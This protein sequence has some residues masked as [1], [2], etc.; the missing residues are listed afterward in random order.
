[1]YRRI[2]AVLA[3]ALVA[4]LGVAAPSQAAVSWKS[5]SSYYSITTN[6]SGLGRCIVVKE[7]GN[8]KYQTSVIVGSDR[9]VIRQIRNPRLYSP[10]TTVLFYDKCGSGRKLKPLKSAR[11]QLVTAWSDKKKH[12]GSGY[13]LSASVPWGLS[14]SGTVSSGKIAW[15]KRSYSSNTAT[16]SKFT[17]TSSGTAARW[18]KSAMTQVAAGGK[19][20]YPKIKLTNEL[21]KL[22]I[23]QGANAHAFLGDQMPQKSVTVW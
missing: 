18:T 1:M 13:G 14:V 17:I 10:Q 7:T 5:M 9:S 15:A 8:I 3:A 22:V 12:Y 23:H 6:Y 16:T 2:A 4:V 21:H 19:T 11:V 20:S